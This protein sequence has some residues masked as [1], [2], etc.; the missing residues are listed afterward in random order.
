ME[1]NASGS[2]VAETAPPSLGAYFLRLDLV[3]GRWH[4]VA[5]HRSEQ[6][7]DGMTIPADTLPHEQKMICDVYLSADPASRH[8][9]RAIAAL[10][11]ETVLESA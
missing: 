8:L 7:P 6:P 9:I 10:V 5:T 11:C 1:R 2:F 3:R 4:A